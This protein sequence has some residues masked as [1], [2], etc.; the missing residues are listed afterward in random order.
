MAFAP[1]NS[2]FAHTR[3][4]SAVFIPPAEVCDLTRVSVSRA[5]EAL[6]RLYPDDGY[7]KDFEDIG[8]S[9]R[10]DLEAGRLDARFRPAV[11]ALHREATLARLQEVIE[12]AGDE[13][14]PAFVRTLVLNHLNPDLDGFSREQNENAFRFLLLTGRWQERRE[15]PADE[16]RP[17][18][19]KTA[20]RLADRLG[21]ERHLLEE[22][23]SLAVQKNPLSDPERIVGELIPFLGALETLHWPPFATAAI[24]Y[25]AVENVWDLSH[26]S[27]AIQKQVD[28][29]IDQ[30]RWE[31]LMLALGTIHGERWPLL[32]EYLQEMES[33]HWTARQKISFFGH[34]G[35]KASSIVESATVL[36]IFSRH[37]LQT[38]ESFRSWLTTEHGPAEFDEPIQAPA[39]NTA[40]RGLQEDWA[41]EAIETILSLLFKSR[42][43]P[44]QR[45][46]W[47][48]NLPALAD[49]IRRQGLSGEKNAALFS[50][51]FQRRP[52]GFREYEA[53]LREGLKALFRPVVRRRRRTFADNFVDCFHA[54]FR[55]L[56]G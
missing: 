26:L 33:S 51:C 23:A 39:L 28:F 52:D 17:P 15:R 44:H 31:S 8:L 18:L 34:L 20:F 36:K 19:A 6:G 48:K 22:I 5:L 21:W 29:G 38:L 24:A 13:N 56:F 11:E 2:H 46:G 43:S 1:L 50:L 53:V 54:G 16:D 42:L 3:M 40:V 47:L 25:R 12:Q 37:P 45:E 41:P 10:I 32:V 7:Q 14:I 55:F 49:A 35:G 27:T 9:L 30:D 4:P